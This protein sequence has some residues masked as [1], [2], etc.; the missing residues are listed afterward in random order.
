MPPSINSGQ[1]KVVYILPLYDEKTGTHFSY[2]YE[3]IRQASSQ[4]D[5][6]AVVEK[7]D[8]AVKLG[9]PFMAQK[10]KN[11]F[12]RFFELF[13]TLWNLRSK[14]Y[15]NFYVHYSYYGALA[16]WLVVLF[17]GGR[18]FYWNRGMPWLFERS[19]WEERIF[20]FIL[21]HTILV[22]GPKLLAEEYVK[23]YKV[24]NYKILSNW[25]DVERFKPRELKEVTKS[26]FSVKGEGKIVLFAHHLSERKGADLIS[27]I[28]SGFNEKSVQ[29]FVV[30]NGPYREVLEKKARESGGLIKVFGEIPNQ[31]IAT[32]FQA[33]DVFLM[34]SR[35][36]GSPHVILEALSSG[37]P[38][39]ASDAGG[40]K[41]VMPAGLKEFLCKTED[42]KCFQDKIKKLLS[43]PS[44]YEKIRQEGL[45]F[46]KQFDKKRGVEE[47]ISLFL[48]DAS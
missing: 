18:V 19:F 43:D 26:W 11:R 14:G 32:Y 12:L 38:V 20:G 36:E 40:V 35:E 8:G 6:F 23:R 10:Y 21:R 3:L 28:A 27:E 44:E 15:Q 29:F 4:I 13:S 37:T 39:V 41:E 25:I 48:P 42:V 24:K 31:D 5:L 9:A 45:E 16:S 33:A 30:G 46:V 22:T 2:N 17:K 7:T 34:P 1:A 47:F